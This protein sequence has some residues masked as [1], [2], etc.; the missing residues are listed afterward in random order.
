[1][2]PPP[3]A[4]PPQPQTRVV[5]H[6]GVVGSVGSPTAP[7]DY[8][9]YDPDTKT[10]ID[11]LHAAAPDIDFSKMVDDKI[12]VTG[13]EGVEPGWPN[14]PV[15]YVTD[16]QVVATNVIK[17]FSSEELTIPRLRH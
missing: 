4:A 11:Y 2:T 5:Q 1:M 9:L 8:K 13:Q 16:V 17:H 15:I 12:I 6:E 7:D 3:P 10:D 14:T